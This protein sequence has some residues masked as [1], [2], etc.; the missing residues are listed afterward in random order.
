MFSAKTSGHGSWIAVLSW[1]RSQPQCSP[2][3][4]DRQGRERSS[5]AEGWMLL[6]WA[7]GAHVIL[8]PEKLKF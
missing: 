8:Y 1:C 5:E 3:I 2:P 4:M 6:G 7:E